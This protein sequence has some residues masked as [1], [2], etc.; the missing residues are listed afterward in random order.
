MKTTTVSRRESMSCRTRLA[1]PRRS[2][3]RFRRVALGLSL[4]GLGVLGAES[5]GNDATR[6]GSQSTSA[7]SPALQ[8]ERVPGEAI[9]RLPDASTWPGFDD[10]YRTIDGSGNHPHDTAMGAAH[11]VLRRLA[12][13]TYADGVSAMAGP[14]RPHPRLISNRFAELD[15]PTFT[16]GPSDFL[17]QWGQFLDHDLSLTD[18]VDP[19]EPADIAI[20]GDD[21]RFG[22]QTMRFNRSLYDPASG[23]NTSNPREQI[24]EITSWIDAS[25]V[26][27]SDP[28]RARALRRLDG[29]GGLKTS[30]GELL[31]FNT[32]GLPNAGGSGGNLFLAGDVRANEQL[33]LLSLH[34]LFVRE[35]NRLANRIRRR[36][37][38]MSGDEIYEEARRIVAAQMQYITYEEYLPVLLGKRA[39]SRY[40]GYDTD[41]DARL[42]NVFTTGLYRYGH[43]AVN[44][45]LRRLDANGAASTHGHLALR[46]AFFRPRRLI[47]EGGIEPILRGLASQVARRIDLQVVDGLRNFLFSHGGPG[48]FDLVALNIQ[49]GRDHGLPTYNQARLALGL[50]P[51]TTFRAISADPAVHRRLAEL[52]RDTDDID[53]WVGAL[54][55]PTYSG[56]VGETLYH[57]MKEQFEVLR[58]G[59][60]YWYEWTLSRSERRQLGKLSKIIRRNT[61]IGRELP[62]DVFLVR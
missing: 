13:P 20:A 3:G 27:G 4:L 40:R 41:V 58:D 10:R 21:P 54:A 26:Y 53:V 5:S 11:T 45:T 61:S 18:G 43:S 7:V 12:P 46:D 57:G 8:I 23:F 15:D 9:I 47:D 33:G 31:P 37:A 2:R 17:W 48:G 49:R 30:E 34:T 50:E 62:R 36:H 59:D 32:A 55:E 6:S 25:N 56:M 35:H 38:Y 28:V 16:V 14:D 52:Y 44:D 29:S 22:G 19:A 51:A 39:L 1:A 24:N 42:A 60:R